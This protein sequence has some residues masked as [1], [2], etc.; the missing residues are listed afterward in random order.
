MQK[1][2]LWALIVGIIFMAIYMLF[3]FATIRKYIPPIILAGVTIIT[4]F[5]DISIPT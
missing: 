2:A 3:S 4:M 1:A 5:F